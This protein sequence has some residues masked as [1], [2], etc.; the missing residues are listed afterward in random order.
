MVWI[1]ASAERSRT[2]R[3]DKE[4]VLALLLDVCTSGPFFPGVDAIEDLG[5][6]QFRWTLATRRTLGSSFTG[7]YIAKYEREGDAVNWSTVEGNM[8][9]KGRWTV[10]GPDGHLRLSV[11]VTSELDAPV[12]KILKKPAVL[13]AE[14][15]SKNGLDKQLD[16]IEQHLSR[17]A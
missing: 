12:P 1:Q 14:L 7:C 11:A 17:R 8:T 15:E 13:F 9:V 4:T 5:E 10:S 3:A 16:K 6:G 2:V